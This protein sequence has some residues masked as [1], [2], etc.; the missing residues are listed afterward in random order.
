M[1]AIEADRQERFRLFGKLFALYPASGGL[2]VEV[3]MAAYLDETRRVPALALSHAM[4]RLVARRANAF[5]P[6]VYEILREA[7]IWVR[8]TN[9]RAAGRDPDAHNPEGPVEIDVE[10][11]L[12]LAPQAV[13]LLAAPPKPLEL[14]AQATRDERDRAVA[15]LDAL[16]LKHAQRMR[17]PEAEREAG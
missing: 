1:N 13:Q 8:E 10:R 17:L 9:A 12:A 14:P 4:K 3:R 7:A 15:K 16:V 2:D 5:V 6:S 11:W